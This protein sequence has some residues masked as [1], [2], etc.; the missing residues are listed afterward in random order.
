MGVKGLDPYP[1][2]D[3]NL[4]LLLTTIEKMKRKLHYFNVPILLRYT[5]P[6]HLFMELGPQIGLLY[7]AQDEFTVSL[8]SKN[9][10]VYK[11]D[12]K[13]QLRRLDAGIMAGLGYHLFAGR[14]MNFGIRYYQ[15]FV[16][17]SKDDDSKKQ[18]NSS[19]YLFASI[20][21]GSGASTTKKSKKNET[22]ED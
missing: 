5:L 10:L 1:L 17:I 8:N 4:D 7:K 12:I 18:W 6:K 22:C 15:G 11:I 9:D 19:I 14:G 20:P 2:F 16:N 3:P 21:I 13:D